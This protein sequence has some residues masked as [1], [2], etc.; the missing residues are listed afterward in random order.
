MKICIVLNG[1]VENYTKIRDFITKED[2]DYIICADGGANHTYYMEIT[3]DY[4][5]GDLDS[6]DEKLVS[7]YKNTGV[8]FEKFPAKKDETDTELCIYL[9][10]DL[11]A[12]RIDFIAALGGRIDHTITNI[13]LLYYL[14]EM[15]IIPRIISEKEEMYIAVNEEITISGNVGDIVSVIAINGDA[16]GVT[17]KNL[18]YPLDNYY[19][20][21]GVPIGMSNVMLSNECKVKVKKGNLIIIKNI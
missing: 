10:R 18:E 15:D 21:Y 16:D 3:P 11:K 7:Y 1:E 4:I 12:T 14:K 8:K 2:Y 6:V 13:N 9:A 17:L 19:M 5:I 20:K